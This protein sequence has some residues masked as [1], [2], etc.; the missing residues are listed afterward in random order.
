MK[1][2]GLYKLILCRRTSNLKRKCVK[3]SLKP[4]LNIFNIILGY[5]LGHVFYVKLHLAL[6]FIRQ[7]Y[8]TLI[9]KSVKFIRLGGPVVNNICLLLVIFRNGFGVVLVF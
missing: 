4:R 9:K 3:C 1:P 7:P 5:V 8:I 2:N 6:N